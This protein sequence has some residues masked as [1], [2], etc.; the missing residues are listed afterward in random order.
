MKLN[1][2]QRLVVYIAG[3]LI[4]WMLLVPPW[5]GA[6]YRVL[7]WRPP[8]AFAATL[9]LARLIVQCLA[10]LVWG[11]LMLMALQKKQE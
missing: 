6:G 1:R 11:A 5:L 2:A 8:A 3:V 7:W 10:V 4:L 9:D